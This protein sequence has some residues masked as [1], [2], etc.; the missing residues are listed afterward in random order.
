MIL[1]VFFGNYDTDRKMCYNHG[2]ITKCPNYNRLKEK[3]VAIEIKNLDIVKVNY[4]F[5]K[6]L[7]CT[8]SKRFKVK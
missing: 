3:A 8:K 1:N 2:M 6:N 5:I 7:T 4:I